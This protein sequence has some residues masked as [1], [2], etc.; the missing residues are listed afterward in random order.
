[1]T[2]L[3]R[4]SGTTGTIGLVLVLVL[5]L[6]LGLVLG[7]VLDLVLALALVLALVM[8]GGRTWGGVTG[9]ISIL[10]SPRESSSGG[11]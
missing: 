3:W 5:V 6:V 2:L 8:G 9:S 10:R 7:M 1:M 11:S 4:M